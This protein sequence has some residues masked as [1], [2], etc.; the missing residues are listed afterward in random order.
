MSDPENAG[1]VACIMSALIAGG[2]L[3]Y[4]GMY[5]I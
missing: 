3:Y 1:V 5:L 2:V 4:I